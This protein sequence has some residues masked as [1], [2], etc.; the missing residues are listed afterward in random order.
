[1]AEYVFVKTKE[2]YQEAA[3]LFT[4][5]ASWLSIDLGFQHFDEELLRLQEM[6]AAPNGG[7]ILARENNDSIACVAIRRINPAIAELK[8]M[9][10]KPEH[11]HQ[12]IGQG[13]LDKAIALALQ[14]GYS[15]IRLDT[16]NY[17]TPAMNLYKKNGFTEIDAYYNNPNTTAV[18]FELK[19]KN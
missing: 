13:L 1:M 16:L 7:I 17:M 12:G 10:V 2:N 15:L 11:Q 4:E 8:R 19:I 6:Y 3:K 9:Y 14:C 5:Y 18:Y